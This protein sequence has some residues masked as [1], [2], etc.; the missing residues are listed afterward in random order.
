M[1]TCQNLPFASN[2]H[3]PFAHAFDYLRRV[4]EIS[5]QFSDERGGL[6]MLCED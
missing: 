2:A 3:N 1:E 5:N 6:F 4:M